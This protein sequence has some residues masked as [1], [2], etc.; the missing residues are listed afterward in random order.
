MPNTI[1]IKSST[2]AG[3]TPSLQEGEL[4][5]NIED[6]KLWV[7]DGSNNVLLNPTASTNA[8][9]LDNLDST[10][11][12]RADVDDTV[13]K[14]LTFPSGVGDRPILQGGFYSRLTGD[15]D[16]DIWGISETFYPSHSTNG[17]AWGIRWSSSPN[18]IQFVGNGSNKFR[19][20]LDTAGKVYYDDNELFTVAGGTL[21]G[22]LQITENGNGV[23]VSSKFSNTST[24]SGAFQEIQGWSGA[25]YW[26][27]GVANENYSSSVWRKTTWLYSHGG[28]L[29]LG[30]NNSDRAWLTTTSFYP[31]TSGHDLGT[32]AQRWQ[33]YATS[34]DVSG[35]LTVAGSC[36]FAALSGTT[37]TF[38]GAVTVTGSGHDN[39]TLSITNTANSNARLLLNSGHGNWSVCNSDT[40]GDAL[41]FR[42]ESAGATRLSIS[43][44]GTVTVNNNLTVVGSASLSTDGSWVNIGGANV[45]R[46]SAGFLYFGNANFGSGL[47]T[48]INI[49]MESGYNISPY[50]SSP[51]SSTTLGTSANRWPTIYGVAGSFSGQVTAAT[52]KSTGTI[53]LNNNTTPSTAGGEAFLYKHSSNGTVLSGYNASI[54]TGSAGSRSV[55][56]SVS[57]A[58][59]VTVNNNLTVAG[60]CTFAALSGTT[61]TFSGKVTSPNLSNKYHI[62]N[63]GGSASWIKLG[64]LNT[65]QSGRNVFLRIV[66]AS[67]YNALESQNTVVDVYFRTSNGS[68]SQSGD[69]TDGGSFYG[70]ARSQRHT[71]LG[72][73][74]NSPSVIRIVQ[75]SNT[76][77][78]FYGSFNTFVGTGSFY[79]VTTSTSDTWTNSGTTVSE[80][81][82]GTLINTYPL[83]IPKGA[84]LS[85]KVTVWD[86]TNSLSYDTNLN[87][88]F[89]NDR[90]GIGTSAPA[91]KLDIYHNG[92]FTNDVPTARI[93]HRNY[94]DSGNSRVAALDINVGMSNADLFHHGYVQLY[95]HFTGGA[96]NSPRLYFSSNSYNSSTNHRQW[97][98]IQALADTTA[99]GDR[100]AFTCDLSSTN[101][102]ATPVHIMSLLT[103]GRCGIGVTA[104]SAK[105]HVVGDAFI[106]NTG[107]TGGLT[108]KATS[109]AN[110]TLQNAQNTGYNAVLAAHYNWTTPMTLSGYGA[111]V[112]AMNS[113]IQKTLLYANNAERVRITATGVGIGLGG[114]DP[115][116]KLHVNGGSKFLGGGDY[117][118]I[119]RVTTTDTNFSLYVTSTSTA[120][121]QGIA[122]FTHSATAGTAGSGTETAVIARDKSYFYSKLG[123]GLNNPSVSLDIASTDAA[124]IKLYRNSGNCSVHI[125]NSGDDVYLGVNSYNNVCLG[126]QLDQT[127]APFQLRPSTGNL[128]L[129][130]ASAQDKLNIHD[131]SSSANLGLKITRGSQT[132]GLRL[133]VNDSHAFLW[134]D[135]SQ[136]LAFANND[137]ERLTIKAS[138]GYVQVHQ[139]LGIGTASPEGLLSFKA[140]E[141]NTPKI[142]FQNQHSDNAD[143]AISTYDDTSGTTV[144]I[145]SNLYINSS[146]STTRFNT[147]E[148]SAGFRA[149][150]GGLLQFYTGETGATA[151]ERIRVT[152]GG[153]V[154]IGVTAPSAKLHVTGSAIFSGATSWAGNDTQTCA[155]YL[156]NTG[157]GLYGNFSN[158]ARNLVK[159][160]SNYVEVG[161][162]STLVYGVKFI[163]GSNAP[164]G[165]MFQ[166]NIGGT[167]TT[168]MGIRGDTGSV[169]IGT[170]GT[171]PYAY[172]TTATKFEV[173]TG[174]TT[175]GEV[176]VARFRG[177]DDA[178][179]GAAVVRIT[180][181]NDR[182]LVLKGGRV[183]GS[184]SAAAFADI[185]VASWDGSFTR[186]IRIDGA[187]RC[188][189]GTA[190]PSAKLHVKSSGGSTYPIR[191]MASDG[192]DLGGIYEDN[193]G[194]GEF[195]LRNAAGTTRVKLN[196]HGD[197]FINTAGYGLGVGTVSP[198]NTLT[199][200]S[201]SQYTRAY[202]SQTADIHI[203]NT[204]GSGVGSYAG[205]ISFCST[206][207]A[208]L[209]AA[210][211]AAIQTGSDQNQ[212]GLT[213]NTQVS[214]AGSTDLA[215]AV[216]IK[217]DGSVGIGASPSY[218][219]DVYKSVTG[220]WLSRIHNTATSG[221]SS[222]LLVRMDEQGST[223]VAFGVY[224][225]GGYKFRVEPDGETQIWSG[226]AYTTHLNYQ[227]TGSHYISTGNSGFT[228]FRGSSNG[229]TA[230]RVNG[231][232]KVSINS[233]SNAGYNL[234]VTGSACIST[235]GTA[236][237]LERS[238]SPYGTALQ[239]ANSSGLEWEIKNSAAGGNTGELAF[240][241]YNG[242]GWDNRVS[243]QQDGDV[244]ILNRLGVGGVHS[245]SY[246]LYVHGTSYFGDNI[247]GADADK[248]AQFGRA[249]VGYI[250][251]SD[252]AGFAH[253][254]QSS[255]TNY[256]LIQSSIGD[257]FVNS[258]SGKSI[259]FRQNNSDSGIINGDQNWGIGTISPGSYKLYVN[260]T[261][262]FSGA[263]EFDGGIK[264]KDGSLGTNGHVLHTNGSD[265]YWAAASGGSSYSLPTASSSTK[266]G[267]KIDGSDF[268]V[269]SST[270]V[271]TLH[272]SVTKRYSGYLQMDSSGNE[273]Y[274]INHGLGT[275][276]VIVQVRRYAGSGSTRAQRFSNDEGTHLDM[277]VECKVVPCDA[278]GGMSSNY[279]SLDFS[280][281]NYS[282]GD[283]VY[284]TI[285]G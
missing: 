263:A 67:G 51:S 144:L 88:D 127:A 153:S 145:G 196:T 25:G 124:P 187:G 128:G 103:N 182:G 221:N 164:N 122:K 120:S 211:I 193:G 59:T 123:V 285:I 131:S 106:D 14:Q 233:S 283:Y 202:L 214:T 257:T 98:G 210:S 243:I 119:E 271:M 208:N 237:K 201:G 19:I 186:G 269:N 253:R 268:T 11:F 232:G 266:G 53:I 115:S 93:Y 180:N 117:T 238:D 129:G 184:G 284:F 197:S 134:T 97:W 47:Y 244:D 141:S 147:G 100:L 55:A 273:Q 29:V 54:E 28:S 85:G 207:E 16:A 99:T 81:T 30:A 216:R 222:G 161:Q 223:G 173:S 17:N 86:G 113:G 60:S 24:A 33:L 258:A 166:S 228:I 152:A 138:T 194:N 143:A 21:T 209:Q 204:S 282:N 105:L 212:I 213:F 250:G 177:G 133:G 178:D 49:R 255:S 230:M 110:I 169:G 37:G 278:N 219:F 107:T 176:E 179:T 165:F 94:P 89:S 18:E 241:S 200:T 116:A 240:R 275:Q 5:V 45:F 50:S 267:I 75:V 148:E 139:L 276:D 20:D 7:G 277:G 63:T 34:G 62:P 195:W 217:H 31:S 252:Y 205:A 270:A 104:P 36:T 247:F 227:N 279:V 154:G 121:N 84:G 215:E 66:S 151:T 183:G 58:G 235:T 118:N 203:A 42:D 225:N 77:Y 26:R 260:G 272:S 35:N 43:S 61:G 64:N 256:A 157:R 163:V 181:D 68:S 242:S 1:K 265:V 78:D 249:R 246:G 199:V 39:A 91:A 236:L 206:A 111:T 245:N 168:H 83:A 95:N 8:D 162:N 73:N 218:T 280:D 251:H 10:Q 150:R 3:N 82:T 190:S 90:L 136:D 72:G 12:V 38:S 156:N 48:R 27:L 69:G 125:K 126:H 234:H 70:S 2:T 135:Q 172:D 137:S 224:A 198:T 155:I 46:K 160:S 262:Y 71:A 281:F 108:V 140:D 40:I 80:P 32:N 261:S 130:T 220:N 65:S 102:T 132:H 248:Y 76:S 159:A 112:L 142:R 167:M 229:V 4:G 101:P 189:I 231:D 239:L 264:D 79:E 114:S 171:A 92:G 192:S 174:T 52:L 41:E 175:V 56:L 158:Y 13:S 170:G 96:Y 226:S 254:D 185:G 146:G 15:G 23:K 149:D 109:N 57:S 6:A 259:F 74:T 9:T 22:Q 274:T 44:A 87:W 191:V 188:G